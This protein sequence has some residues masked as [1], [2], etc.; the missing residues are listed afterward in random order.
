MPDAGMRDLDPRRRGCSGKE[1]CRVSGHRAKEAMASPASSSQVD[2]DPPPRLASRSHA[3][4]FLDP[5]PVPNTLIF[6]FGD[7]TLEL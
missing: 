6:P 1:S 4:P 5:N 3:T 2:D 7:Q